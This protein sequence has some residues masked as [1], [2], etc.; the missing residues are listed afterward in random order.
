MRRLFLIHPTLL[1]SGLALLLSLAGETVHAQT[2]LPLQECITQALVSSPRLQVAKSQLEASESV[3]QA[4]RGQRLPSVAASGNLNYVSELQSLDIAPNPA[5]PTGM[6]FTFGDNLSYSLS[7]G[8]RAPLYAGGS[9]VSQERAYLYEASASQRDFAADSL[10]VL[11]EVRS[12]YYRAL[13]AAEA[14]RLTKNALDRLLRHQ[15]DVENMQQAGMAD[16]ETLLTLLSHIREAE[17]TVASVEA[18]F[19]S[20][21]LE[22]GRV[23]GRA[24]EEITANGGLSVSLDASVTTRDVETRP[25]LEAF[26]LRAESAS[27]RVHAAKGSYLPTVSAMAAFNYGKPGVN[28]I[29]NEWMSYATAGISLNW[30][31]F[32]WSVR[33]HTV[34]SVRSSRQKLLESKRAVAEMWQTRQAAAQARLESA[35]RERTAAESRLEL[36][37]KR[38][39]LVEGKRT[40]GQASE[41]DLLDAQDDLS[42]A[43]IGLAQALAQERLAETE[44]LYALGR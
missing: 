7:L 38:Y 36:E 16:E 31:V 14:N 4:S 18:G 10:T 15:K 32:D 22:L 6:S 44:L 17:Q 8:V 27:R 29:Q 28:Y 19:R 39:H 20:A 41:R 12:A 43:E 30:T 24:G 21:Q 13:A 42:S 33:K 35:R 3:A 26:D 5:L 2:S 11:Y 25:D 23:I 40:Q 9:L 1:A 37:R 34:Q